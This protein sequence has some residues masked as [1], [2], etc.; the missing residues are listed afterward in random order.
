MIACSL[1]SMAA[2]VW[3]VPLTMSVT[4]G[5]K[6][7]CTPSSIFTTSATNAPMGTACG[8]VVVLAIFVLLFLATA[9]RSF[10]RVRLLCAPLLRSLRTTISAPDMSKVAASMPGA[11]QLDSRD[12]RL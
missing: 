12:P 3:G 4:L 8:F 9:W 1:A 11:K 5:G 2:W 7:A 10:A 6:F